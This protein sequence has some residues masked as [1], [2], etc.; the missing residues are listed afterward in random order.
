M[1][2]AC[3]QTEIVW[4]DQARNFLKA[5]SLIKNASK[6]GADLVCL[7]ELFSTGV[8][9]DSLK[10][11]EG[12]SGPT[13]SFLSETSKK[14]G[15]YILGSFIEKSNGGELPKN[16]VVLY[17]H[18][19][20]LV[21]KY[22]KNHVFTF[23]NECVSYSN[24]SG[25]ANYKIG[26]FVFFPFICYDLR[27]P[28][29]FRAAIDKGANAFIISANWPNPRKEHWMTLLK[30]RAI[31]N[32][33]YVIGINRAGKSPDLTFFGS[34]MILSPKGEVI[35]EAGDKEEIIYGNID[36]KEVSDWREKFT[37]LKDRRKDYYNSL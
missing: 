5:G 31:E 29:I 24:G 21:C 28:E 30:T 11:A 8:T 15:T 6:E 33:S 7:P 35:A 27:F 18:Y 2:I 23:G 14:N 12:L 32:Q 3:V 10:F 25:I 4:E 37:A 22:S 9:M 17:D 26:E 13:C 1:K 19:G 36:A 20:K 34:S 16:S